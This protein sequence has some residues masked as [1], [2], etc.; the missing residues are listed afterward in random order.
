MRGPERPSVRCP[1]L[2]RC[3]VLLT[4]LQVLVGISVGLAQTANSAGTT[5]PTKPM[6]LSLEEAIKRAQANEPTYA[7]AQADSKIAD[8]DRW[9]A[10][11]QLLPNILYHN[12][13]LYTQPVSG[14]N[15]SAVN[16][17]TGPAPRFIANNAVHEY[18]SQGVVN[19]TIGLAGWADVR[20]A[21]A[22]A[23]R[24]A[25]EFE[26]A[27]RG[28]VATVSGLYY[29]LASTQDRLAI[30]EAAH[31]EASD[32]TSL[33]V[34]RE[35]AREAAHADVVKAQ[36]LEQ[37]RDRELSD[38]RVVAEKA[39][40]ELAVL[41]FP[42]P[43]TPFAVAKDDTVPALATRDDVN[44]A[45]SKN[46]PELR[47]AF[48]SMAAANAEVLAS[49]AAYLPDLALNYTYGIDSPQ[50]AIYGPDHSRNLGYSASVTVDLPV[51]DW[52]STQRKVKQSEIRR[53]ATQVV[54]TATQKHLVARLDEAYSEAAAA[55]DQLQSLDLS[56]QT[57]AESLRLTKL[58]YQ[59]GESTVLEVVDA[60]TAYVGA[61]N[62]RADGRVRYQ[63]ALA[64]LQ[65]LTG[66]M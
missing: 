30:A 51:W 37:Q 25:A 61:E 7:A 55:R 3:L 66:A 2:G 17:A 38:A 40:L 33:T 21:N 10:K 53:K 65:T 32:F 4:S 5:D 6:V 46:N 8:L 22:N 12:Q 39:R 9:N 42:D 27:R 48:A 20:L 58:R 43:H 64:D 62:A 29:G 14:I 16:G 49:R 18:M 15:A 45:A 56:V 35:Q 19:E 13:M 57:A 52:L 41:V 59:Q 60:E 44:A 36:L 31:T 23:L 63:A 47:S 24:A 54:L 26:I 28:L 1:Q 34:K 11:S 50:F